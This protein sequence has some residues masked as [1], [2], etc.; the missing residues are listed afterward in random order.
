MSA[1]LK[2]GEPVL[3]LLTHRLATRLVSVLIAHLERSVSQTTLVDIG[4]LLSCQQRNAEWQHEPSEPVNYSSGSHRFLPDKVDL[5]CSAESAALLFPLGD[6]QQAQ[7]QM[8]L[9]ELR[10]WLAIMHRQ[11]KKAGWPMEVWP[12]WFTLAESGRN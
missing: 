1:T 7:L 4:L 6:G 11:Y 12:E 5:I 8:S 9:L 10:Q 3:F 2:E